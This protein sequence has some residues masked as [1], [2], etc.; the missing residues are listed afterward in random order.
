MFEANKLNKEVTDDDEGD[1]CTKMYG[2]AY[3]GENLWDKNELYQGEKYGIKLEYLEIDEFLN[4]N[5]LNE[6]DAEFLEHLQRQTNNHTITKK[7][8]VN[9][10]NSSINQTPVK[11]VSGNSSPNLYQN[12]RVLPKDSQCQSQNVPIKNQHSN[13]SLLDANFIQRNS[14][15]NQK[16]KDSNNNSNCVFIICFCSPI[17]CVS[18]NKTNLFIMKQ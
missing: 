8:S 15:K 2:N 16:Q 14:A 9:L 6:A 10:E 11:C 18:I 5:R 12:S 4:E 17:V 3:L 1:K 7:N 13:N